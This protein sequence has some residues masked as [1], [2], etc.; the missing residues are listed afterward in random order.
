MPCRLIDDLHE[1]CNEVP[2]VFTWILPNITFWCKVQRIPVGSED[3]VELYCSLWLQ[4]GV[5]C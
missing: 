4:C 2:T 5:W 1:W 3:P